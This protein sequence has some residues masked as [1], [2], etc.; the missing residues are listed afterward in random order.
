M[1][2]G[3]NQKIKRQIKTEKN[4]GEHAVVCVTGASGFTG[5]AAVDCL[6]LNGYSVLATDHPRGSFAAV[7]AHQRFMRLHPD[8]YD[9]VTLEIEPADLTKPADL[10]SLFRGR[11]VKYL[12]HPA[13][14]FN[15]SAPKSLLWAVN[16]EGTRN[17]L[18][19]AAEYAPGLLG[20][21]V[22]S[23][24][25]VYGRPRGA[26]PVT[27][28]VTPRPT[29][30]YTRSK[31]EEERVALE[32]AEKG[33]PVV[34]LRTAAVYGPRGLYGIARRL[35]HLSWAS[36]FPL[37]VI[38]GAGTALVHLA[39][40]DDVVASA[41]HLAYVMG[42]LDISGQIF[43]VA[44][45][46]PMP[47]WK[48]IEDV[49]GMLRLRTPVAHLPEPIFRMAGTMIPYGF[50]L[51]FYKIEREELPR[52]LWSTAYDNTKLK[53][54]GYIFKYP[55]TYVGLEATFDW[56]ARH[57]KMETI[58][59]LTHPGWRNYW[60]HIAPENRPFADYALSERLK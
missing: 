37:L 41:L 22:W 54:T 52:M 42:R 59:Y 55:R 58:W 5:S 20:A 19:A 46:T 43:N 28:D 8:R 50:T 39:H 30:H 6:L 33:L 23:T 29:T 9:G 31:L 36:V 45:D 17:L 26:V 57:G 11:P 56:Y 47:T 7:H 51:P 48:M 38:P 44:D 40:M 18:N 3:G 49:A 12:L 15:M 60:S 4:M 34:I 13:A 27:E 53:E 25:M 14:V 2:N 32:F 1:K 35:K 10:V 21:V 16:V 24:A